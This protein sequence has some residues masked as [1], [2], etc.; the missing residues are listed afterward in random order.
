MA[1]EI[2]NKVAQSTLITLDLK[3]LYPKGKRIS[4][5]IEPFL[6]QGLIVKEKVQGSN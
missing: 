5:D 1:K 3:E 2:I 4:F 6:F